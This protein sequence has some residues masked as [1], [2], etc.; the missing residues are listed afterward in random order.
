MCIEHKPFINIGYNQML[1]IGVFVR[2]SFSHVIQNQFLQRFSVEVL[3]CYHFRF[4][5]RRFGF[6]NY[7]NIRFCIFT[8]V[9]NQ[10][11]STFG[12]HKIIG[13]IISLFKK[14]D[15]QI[16]MKFFGF[17]FVYSIENLNQISFETFN[18]YSVWF[19]FQ[20]SLIECFS[21]F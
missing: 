21:R 4:I 10:V 18:I 7:A 6:Y 13:I 9:N 12:I 19:Y 3:Y 15:N 17:F 5:T 14:I 16:F 2:Y 1:Q 11:V 8:V 20:K